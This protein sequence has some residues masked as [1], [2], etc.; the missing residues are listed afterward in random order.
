MLL[1]LLSILFGVNLELIWIDLLGWTWLGRLRF[2]FVN[3]FE[4]SSWWFV[5]KS[6]GLLSSTPL[7]FLYQV[8]YLSNF[9]MLA[10][11]PISGHL[12]LVHLEGRRVPT[13]KPGVPQII[14]HFKV[15]GHGFD[16]KFFAAYK[17]E[18]GLIFNLFIFQ[19]CNLN[20]NKN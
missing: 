6:W 20:R 11:L 13:L 2:L 8:D 18:N 3:G 10:T 9:F 7:I 14:A 12:G 19:H 4:W 17:A 5:Q 1:K 16:G 15:I